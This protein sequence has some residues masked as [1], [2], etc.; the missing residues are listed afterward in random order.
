MSVAK[1]GKPPVTLRLPSGKVAPPEVQDAF[2]AAYALLDRLAPR[3]RA[4]EASD[5]S[6]VTDD[7]A[8]RAVPLDR[9]RSASS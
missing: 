3:S 8:K 5:L 4:E 6:D 1:P 9:S 2:R 7:E